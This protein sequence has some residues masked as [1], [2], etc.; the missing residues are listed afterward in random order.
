[1]STVKPLRYVV[2]NPG[3]T[4]L[5]HASYNEGCLDINGRKHA[6]YWAIQNAYAYGGKIIEER[7][8]GTIKTIRDYTQSS[9]RAGDPLR[10]AGAEPDYEP[11]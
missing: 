9:P 5:E 3:E 8:D 10:P 1:M 7:S 11:V 6:L 2:L 4:A